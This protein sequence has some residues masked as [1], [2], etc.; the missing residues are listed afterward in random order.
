MKKHASFVL[1]NGEEY[2]YR[3]NGH[4]N[5]KILLI[6]DNF[7][8]SRYFQAIINMIDTDKYA[9]YAPDLRG[10]GHS[11]YKNHTD[12][13]FEYANDLQAFCNHL[14]LD[15]L[16]V[17]GWG[18]GAM[19][20]LQLTAQI[21]DNAKQVI[22]INPMP[23]P[24]VV[25][26]DAL[27]KDPDIKQLVTDIEA[28][29]QAQLAEDF[30]RQYY[31][32]MTPSFQEDDVLTK[33]TLLQRNPLDLGW[34]TQAHNLTSDTLKMINQNVQ[35]LCGELDRHLDNDFLDELVNQ[36]PQVT[37]NVIKHS[38]HVMMIDDPQAIMQTIAL[39]SEKINNLG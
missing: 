14:H 18:I 39:A 5:Q 36:L 1:P 24:R 37:N 16:I 2:Y 34:A 6:H 33:E 11:S 20:A 29:D 13:F 3:K 27:M 25:D 35:I 15:N 10:C 17:V 30:T 4:G 38:G 9:V 31:P 19:L 26:E 23:T 28:Q 8:T 22:L 7:T 12:R 21:S 32:Y